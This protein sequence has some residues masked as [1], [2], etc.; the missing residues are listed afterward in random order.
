IKKE[1]DRS[2]KEIILI[3]ANGML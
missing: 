2:T 3:M 1:S